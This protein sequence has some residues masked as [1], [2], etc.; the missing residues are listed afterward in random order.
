MNFFEKIIDRAAKNKKKI[1]L[2]EGFDRRILEAAS[3]IGN[4]GFADI[5][6][7]G[8]IADIE[9]SAGNLDISKAKII[10]HLKDSCRFD[11][12]SNIF[13]EMR[14]SKGITQDQA[15]EVMKNPLYFGAIM[16][17][18]KD[19][20]GM[21]AGAANSTADTLRCALQTVKTAPE[22]QFF[23]TCAVLVMPDKNWGDDGVCIF[24]DTAMYENPT[25]HELAQIGISA[26]KF[27]KVLNN[28]EPKVAFLSYSTNGSANSLAT[29]KIIDA[30]KIAKEIAPDIIIDGELQFDAAVLP[31]IAKLKF[32]QSKILGNA[33]VFVFPDLNSANI[34]C[35]IAERFGNA[36]L[37][38][39]V[40]QGLANPI[41]D[42]SRGC[43]PK[44]IA[45][46]AAITAIQAAR[47]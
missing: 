36:E 39:P 5:Y 32:P 47:L 46:M 24:T 15:R 17:K 9:K 7:L 14:K 28:S 12:Y 35:K 18:C 8:N 25:P 4:L 33:N 20:D 22:T 34:G 26:A 44:D 29:Q 6:I 30:V 10:D 11:Q 43:S 13:Y 16:V 3:I 41:N 2:P 21:V 31:E 27:I 19:V 37:Y 45:G 40:S 23:S 1:V 38:G 42:L